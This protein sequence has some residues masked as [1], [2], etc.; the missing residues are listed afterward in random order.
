MRSSL[1]LPLSLSKGLF[2]HVHIRRQFNAALVETLVTLR[3]IRLHYEAE[4]LLPGPLELFRIMQMVKTMTFFVKAPAA[5]NLVS[6][7]CNMCN[8]TERL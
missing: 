2:R 8:M 6:L 1:S 4:E 5:T 3:E 7:H